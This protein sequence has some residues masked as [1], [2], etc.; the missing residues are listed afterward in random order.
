[1][2]DIHRNIHA[3]QLASGKAGAR[4][5][6]PRLP[7]P[8]HLEV[9]LGGDLVRLSSPPKKQ[10]LYAS[11]MRSKPA[12]HL[13]KCPPAWRTAS[14]KRWL[15]NQLVELLQPPDKLASPLTSSPPKGYPLT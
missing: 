9:V 5:R 8:G 12:S 3:S 2:P 1:M 15:R 13:S 6:S 11:Q 7:V 10:L 14:K 4:S